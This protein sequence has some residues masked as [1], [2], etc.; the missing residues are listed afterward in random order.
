MELSI[1]A[2]VYDELENLKPLVTKISE[3]VEHHFSEW[4]ILLVNDGSTDGSAEEMERLAAENRRIRPI[5]LDRNYGQTAAMDAGF[6]H[7]RFPFVLTLDAD[8]QNDPRDIPEL[9]AEMGP[10]VGCV[11]GVRVNRKDSRI[12][13]WSSKIANGVRNWLSDETITDTGCSLKL[14]R[15][16]CLD[17]IVLYEGMHRFLPTLVKL[18]GFRVVEVPVSHHARIHGQ[19]KY[20]VWNRL[21]CSFIDLLAVRWMKRRMLRYRLGMAPVTPEIVP[22]ARLLEKPMHG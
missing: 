21:F 16:Q 7:A 9:M 15:K 1:V 6:R 22:T 17:Q 5:H 13:L 14:F 10:G 11:C 19:S 3:A 4:E 2:P 20:G 18:T 12:R 8:L